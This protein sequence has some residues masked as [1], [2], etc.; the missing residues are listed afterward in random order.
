MVPR[1]T[2]NAVAGHMQRASL[3]LEH[4]GLTKLKLRLTYAVF[5]LQTA[6]LVR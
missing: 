2:E 4:I 5:F 3:Q 6:W 1:A